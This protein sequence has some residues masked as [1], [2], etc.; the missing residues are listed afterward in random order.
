MYFV[1]PYGMP[2]MPVQ[3]RFMPGELVLERIGLEIKRYAI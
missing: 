1:T 2:K 3:C